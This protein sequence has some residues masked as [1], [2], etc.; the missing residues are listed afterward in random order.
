[1]EAGRQGCIEEL[2]DVLRYGVDSHLLTLGL[3]FYAQGML[4]VVTRN[5][6]T[7]LKELRL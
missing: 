3:F 7:G 4:V 6:L 5:Q 2:R 1:M